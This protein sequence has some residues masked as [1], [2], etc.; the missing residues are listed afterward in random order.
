M[1]G[2]NRNANPNSFGA[3]SSPSTTNAAETPTH[4]N[5]FPHHG[6]RIDPSVRGSERY[7]GDS[8]V[9]DTVTP[10]RSSSATKTSASNADSGG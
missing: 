2:R 6:R 1:N 3:T 8:T 4:T 5:G 9:T 7:E 10:S